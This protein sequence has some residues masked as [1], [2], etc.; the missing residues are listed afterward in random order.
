MG[1]FEQG[2][3]QLRAETPD[4]EAK[5]S[6]VAI[7]RDITRKYHQVVPDQA[8]RLPADTGRLRSQHPEL[9]WDDPDG[10]IETLAIL[11]DPEALAE[12]EEAQD[13]IATGNLIPLD[14]YAP[15]R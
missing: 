11:N 7:R 4:T 12:L 2:G 15:P 6:P 5:S 10:A 1:T 14:R 3:S 13:D 8:D 9:D